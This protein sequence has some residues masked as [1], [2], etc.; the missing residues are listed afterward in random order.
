MAKFFLHLGK[1]NSYKP[2]NFSSFP[3]ANFETREY[4]SIFSEL[5]YIFS[6][7][8]LIFSDVFKIAWEGK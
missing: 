8:P 3:F 7:F 1:T 5:S 2:R 6:D 4:S